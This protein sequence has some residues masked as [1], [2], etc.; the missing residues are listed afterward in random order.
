MKLKPTIIVIGATGV[1]GGSVACHL[2]QSEKFSVRG[3]TR[4]LE[5]KAAKALQQA[6]AEIIAG[7]LSNKESILKALQGCDGVYGV[8]NFWE[9]FTNEYEHG[10]NL[11]N[12]VVESGVKQF[13]FSTLPH[14]YGGRC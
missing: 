11:V 2:L 4:H 6:G 12:A 7:D 9:H 13:V 3:L 1:Q 8:T 5:G 14:V 10:V